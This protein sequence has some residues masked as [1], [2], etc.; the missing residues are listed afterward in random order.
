MIF[1][2]FYFELNKCKQSG[3]EWI[4][5]WTING[6]VRFVL[7][8]RCVCAFNSIRSLIVNTQRW[9]NSMI[10]LWVL[11]RCASTVHR[12]IG[13]WHVNCKRRQSTGKLGH[14]LEVQWKHDVLPVGFHSW[15]H[16][17][18]EWILFPMKFIRQCSLMPRTLNIVVIYGAIERVL[19]LVVIFH[20]RSQNYFVFSTDFLQLILSSEKK[21]ILNVNMH[22]L[23]WRSSVHPCIFIRI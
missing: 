8:A 10:V 19:L 3:I 17:Q 4:V 23:A 7:N 22:S 13:S 20:R 12:C 2:C 21:W 16:A 1:V 6:L 5:L 15:Q 18:F 14:M 11:R 9:I